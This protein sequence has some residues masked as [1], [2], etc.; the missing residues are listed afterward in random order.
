MSTA[1]F[2]TKRSYASAKNPAPLTRT[3]ANCDCEVIDVYLLDYFD[4]LLKSE[5][6]KD[7]EMLNESR[8]YHNNDNDNDNTTFIFTIFINLR[9]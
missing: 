7:C 9:K 4:E 6:T 2:M 8:N 3:R 5:N 1:T